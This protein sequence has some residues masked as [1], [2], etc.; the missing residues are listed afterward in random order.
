MPAMV[1]ALKDKRL[2]MWLSLHEI[3]GC[4]HLFWRKRLLLYSLYNA[5]HSAIAFKRQGRYERVLLHTLAFFFLN[6]LERHFLLAEQNFFSTP[7]N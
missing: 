7:T 3:R 2:Q 1:V 6:K 4:Y 5:A